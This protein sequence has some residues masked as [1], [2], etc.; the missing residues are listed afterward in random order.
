MSTESAPAT[1]IPFRSLGRR[2]SFT[3]IG[4]VT[5]L[6][7]GFATVAIVINVRGI[8]ADLE[9]KL[10]STANLSSL[11][12][13]TLLWNVDTDSMEDIL[14]AL[15]LDPDIVFAQ[16][17][18]E[19]VPLATHT[20]EVYQDREYESF[21]QSSKFITLASDI[22]FDGDVIGIMELVVS[23]SS[24]REQIVLNIAGIVALTVLV[25][26]AIGITSL[27]VSRRYVA[28][29]LSALQNSA[30]QIA[31]GQLDTPIDAS[32]RDEIG[33]LARDLNTMR[34]SI[35]HRNALLEEA[36][37]T[38]EH[39]VAERTAEL[40]EANEA[41]NAL[42]EQL[43]AENLRLGAEL[44]VTRRIQKMLLPTS[45][46]LRAVEGLDIAGHM[47]PA[48][49]VGGDYY[50]VLQ[51]DGQVKIGIGDVT[52]H[53]LE[54]GV[55]MVMTQS[56]VRA[57][58]TSGE[59]DP[60]SFLDTLN[61]ALYGNVQRIGAD[62]NLTLSLIDYANGEVR[63]SGQHEMMI[64]MRSSGEVELIDTIDLGFPI[65]LDAEIAEF[66]DQ[67]TIELAP[68]DGIVLYTDGI[69]EAENMANEQYG[70][71]RL[72]EVVRTHWDKPAEGIKDA[73]VSDVTEYIGGQVVYDDIT[74]VVAK[75]L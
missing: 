51:H 3:L 53:G 32:S 28:A 48:N 56:A 10:Q 21:T 47:E 16:V 75:Q 72:C 30:N 69:T 29:P 25:I 24:V 36:N 39:R 57:L 65:A 22:S 71:E 41:I 45:E 38:L 62:K 11:S 63:L 4:V 67:T 19:G 7:I 74:L 9:A 42:N 73:V 18:A 49:E 5:L 70:L 33:L 2:F 54:S 20:R 1:S 64:V 55:M 58:L 12:L 35:R 68:G 52:G 59:T 60:V 8:Q 43:Q 40:A 50:D 17:R 15:L 26:I 46:E 44:E 27:V 23:R 66:V 13:Q 6:L 31:G 37:R 61:R 34:E 14:E